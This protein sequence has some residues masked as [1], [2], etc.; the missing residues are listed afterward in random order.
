[1]YRANSKYF[2]EPGIQ[3]RHPSPMSHVMGG[4]H[5]RR[6][7]LPRQAY[8]PQHPGRHPDGQPE[9]NANPIPDSVVGVLESA[10]ALL[11]EDR[12]MDEMATSMTSTLEAQDVTSV[13]IVFRVSQLP[14]LFSPPR[15]C[16]RKVAHTCTCSRT[17]ARLRARVTHVRA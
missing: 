5:T 10:V 6:A 17:A 13:L 12:R 4:R 16:A 9:H 11:R 14:H 15:L 2:G 3:V 7:S 1:M 8:Q